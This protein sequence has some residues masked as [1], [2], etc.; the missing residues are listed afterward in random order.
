MSRIAQ[1]IERN[2]S[3]FRLS[4]IVRATITVS[5]VA[6]LKTAMEVFTTLPRVEVVRIKNK[7]MDELQNVTLN[8]IYNRH[9]V[10][11]LQLIFGGVALKYHSKHFLNELSRADTVFQFEQ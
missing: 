8:F 7:L 11:E 6:E 1:K 5:T 2:G 9:I 10:C 3:K 4:D